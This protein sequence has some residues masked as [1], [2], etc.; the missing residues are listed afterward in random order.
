MVNDGQ[1]EVKAVDA[2]AYI[3]EKLGEMTSMKL[4]KLLY[5]CQAWSLVWDE[6]P[7][8]PE[9]I[10]AWANGPVVREV[11][12]QHRNKFKISSINGDSAKLSDTQIESIDA[13]L[14]HYGDKDSQWL[15]ELTHMEDPWKNARG[16]LP[17]GVRS[18]NVINHA[19]M[20]EYYSSLLA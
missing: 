17:P 12:N 8:F 6:E 13:V 3:L 15:S 5:Y 11:F 4:Q 2:A 1:K 10:Q 19:S 9:E 18:N 7:M 16:N 20:M 14:E